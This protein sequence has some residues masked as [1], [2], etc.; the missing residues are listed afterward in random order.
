MNIRFVKTKN[1][2]VEVKNM[3]SKELLYIEDALGHEQYFKAKCC[4]AQEQLQDNT[5]KNAVSEM[6]QKHN[7]IFNSFLNLLD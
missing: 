3:T 1:S 6:E 7:S 5:L 4:E 2:N